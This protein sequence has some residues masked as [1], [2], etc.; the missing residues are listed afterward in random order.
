[1]QQLKTLARIPRPLG[2]GGC[3]CEEHIN[4]TQPRMIN[5]PEIFTDDDQNTHPCV[6]WVRH[7]EQVK[8]EQDE[9]YRDR[10][11]VV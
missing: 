3:H 1:M 6:V 8:K 4:P 10:K 2:R 7:Q 5:A 9:K 11:S